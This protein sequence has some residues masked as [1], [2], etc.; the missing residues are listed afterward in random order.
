MKLTEDN[1][2]TRI[3]YFAPIWAFPFIAILA[4]INEQLNGAEE[5]W[6]NESF[7]LWVF[8]IANLPMMYGWISGKIPVKE[9]IIFWLLAPFALWV[10]L[11][12]LKLA[13]VG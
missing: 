10:G 4:A 13:I 11:L 6:F 9:M 2:Q 1:F 5:T 3:K 8:L 12:M 7:V